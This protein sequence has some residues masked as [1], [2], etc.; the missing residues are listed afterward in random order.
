MT[1]ERISCIM[2]ADDVLPDDRAREVWSIGAYDEIAPFFLPM[3]GHLV[4]VAGIETG[5]TVLDIGCGTGNVAITAAQRGA[6]VSALDIV[7]EMLETARENADVAGIATVD[8]RTGSATDLPFE[9][10][11]FDVTLSCVGHIFAEPAT[12]AAAELVRV[13]K[14]GGTVAFTSWT[15]SGVVPAMGARLSAYLPPQ[16]EGFEPPFLWGDPEVVSERLGDSVLELGFE[17]ATIATPVMSPSHYWH[18]ATRQSGMFIVALELVDEDLREELD[19]DMLAAIEPYFDRSRNVVE[20][21]YII[22]HA[23]I[24]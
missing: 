18:E 14:T 10:N 24:A 15:P 16:P 17:R 3:A 13:T 20:M 12:E 11:T 8:W 22:T 9:D 6:Q 19:R 23:T 4:E 5:D 7:P 1:Y 21:E 2:R